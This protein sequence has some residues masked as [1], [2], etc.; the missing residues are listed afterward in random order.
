MITWVAV[1]KDLP[2]Q[3]PRISDD[4]LQYKSSDM[5]LLW[6]D[7]KINPIAFG[8]YEDDN[9]YVNGLHAEKVLY[10]AMINGPD[11]HL[12]NVEFDAC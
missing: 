5:V 7:N 6:T 4:G 2:K 8:C 10:W 9:W 1:D 12:L 11:G 3:K